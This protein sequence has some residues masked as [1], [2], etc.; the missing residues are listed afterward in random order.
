MPHT[1]CTQPRSCCIASANL[2]GFPGPCLTQTPKQTGRLV[3]SCK[4]NR[5]QPGTASLHSSTALRAAPMLRSPLCSSTAALSHT[6]MRRCSSCKGTPRHSFPPLPPSPPRFFPVQRD[7]VDGPRSPPGLH[8]LFVPHLAGQLILL[9]RHLGG[10]VAPRSA[11]GVSEQSCRVLAFL[12]P[13]LPPPRA[14][15]P[16]GL[17]PGPVT[18]LCGMRKRRCSR[19]PA[20]RAHMGRRDC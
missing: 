12:P 11:H 2:A 4:A 15:P 19:I 1:G 10:P 14:A 17:C 20:P 18:A 7:E 13:P 3:P 8:P 5:P 6:A 9:W 16:A